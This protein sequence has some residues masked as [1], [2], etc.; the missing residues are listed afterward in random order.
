MHKT[1]DRPVIH[2][3]QVGQHLPEH[4]FG[5]G[6]IFRFPLS[7]LRCQGVC[8]NRVR[9]FVDRTKLSSRIGAGRGACRKNAGSGRDF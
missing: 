5:S 8:Q 6:R 7:A 4:V 9:M 3:S 2:S 1:T